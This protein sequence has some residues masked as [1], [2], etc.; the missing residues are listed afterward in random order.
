MATYRG[1]LSRKDLSGDVHIVVDDRL[2]TAVNPAWPTAAWGAQVKTVNGTAPDGS[3]NVTV[4]VSGGTG[5]VKT[6]NGKSP[7]GNGAVTLAAGDVGAATSSHTHTAAN[8]TDASTVGKAVLTAAD[9]AAAR[10]A[11][12]AGTSSLGLGTTSST[13]KAGNYTPSAAEVTAALGGDVAGARAALGITLPPVRFS[14]ETPTTG[15]TG[16]DRA[17]AARTI[18]GARMRVGTAPAGSALTVQ[19]QHYDGSTW[20]TV[21]TLTVAA[22][23]TT[24]ATAGTL[25]QAQ[26]AGHLLRLNVT[27]VGST[28]P[29][30]DVVVD[31][32]VA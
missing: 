15:T 8:I 19:V 16:T 28:T 10:S 11:I 25:S 12:G 3:G 6:V 14:A 21:A 32:E 24:E 20:T 23:S 7:D 31:V 5:T 27:S 29:A 2:G 9:A 17:P 30:G 26:S 18:T 1:A 22:G 4:S 13:A